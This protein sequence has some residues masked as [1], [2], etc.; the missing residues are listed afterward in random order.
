[1]ASELDQ[2]W[3]DGSSRILK[4]CEMSAS[5]LDSGFPHFADPET[6]AWTLSPQG[7]WTG[8]YFCAILWLDAHLT[9]SDNVRALARRFCAAL[10]PRIDSRTVFRAFL[11]YYG[12]ALGAIVCGDALARELALDGA[13]AL[14][15]TYNARARCFGL[16]E[17]AEEASDVGNCETS[18]DAVGPLCALLAWAGAQSGDERMGAIAREH[19]LTHIEFCLRPD[20]SVCQS[21]TFDENT[22]RL[23]RRY[24]HKGFAE[25]ST[26][27]RA[28]AWGMLGYTFAARCF[29]QEPRLLEAAYQTADWW[30]AHAPSDLVAFWDF[31]HPAIPDTYRDT[32]ATAIAAAALLKLSALTPEAER[33]R[34]YRAFAERV[35]ATL[36]RNY[37]TPVSPTDR[38]PPGIL[39]EGC[40][41]ARIGLAVKN[42][43][44]WGTYYLLESTLALSGR[45]DPLAL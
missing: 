35:A 39:T 30:L 7:D 29:P 33:A 4:R 18:I 8:G 16:G 44:I 34:R 14:A 23:I 41:N 40:Y 45:I 43:L 28:Q 22:G 25:N 20:G 1:M 2:L 15:T 10:G 26:W 6:G 24:T 17:Q 3:L 19:A 36:V 38:R 9:G 31:D 27:A 32:S 42:E 12:A 13:R 37:L 5:E 11:F 21:A